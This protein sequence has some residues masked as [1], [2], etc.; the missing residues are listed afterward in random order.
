MFL[1]R[2]FFT[3]IPVLNLLRKYLTPKAPSTT[4]LEVFPIAKEGSPKST[5]S[6][7]EKSC[8]VWLKIKPAPK[9]K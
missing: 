4:L 5:T 3:E 8:E 1:S 9:V 6:T 7:P 2:I